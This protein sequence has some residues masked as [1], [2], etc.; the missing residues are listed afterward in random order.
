MEYEIKDQCQEC[1]GFG[2]IEHQRSETRF[3]SGVCPE[4]DGEAFTTVHET[5]DSIQ[6]LRADYPDAAVEEMKKS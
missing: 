5:Y 2:K 4:C 1:E 3:A 6:D